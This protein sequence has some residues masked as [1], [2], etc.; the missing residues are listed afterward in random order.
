[1]SRGMDVQSVIEQQRYRNLAE[2]FR[3][4]GIACV[5]ERLLSPMY[6]QQFPCDVVWQ[7]DDVVVCILSLDIDEWT[8]DITTRYWKFDIPPEA[9]AFR[10]SVLT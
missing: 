8:G 10:V 1:M 3:T 4:N 9:R 5:S 6:P 2:L 7:L